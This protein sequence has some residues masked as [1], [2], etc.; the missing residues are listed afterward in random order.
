MNNGCILQNRTAKREV[1]FNLHI[2][3]SLPYCTATSLYSKVYHQYLAKNLTAQQLC[4]AVRFFAKKNLMK[5]KLL[6]VCAP[7]TTT[8]LPFDHFIIGNRKL[9]LTGTIKGNFLELTVLLQIQ[10]KSTCK[11]PL[12]LFAVL[13]RND[14]TICQLGRF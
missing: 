9:T 8:F 5:N 2:D 14:T 12:Q 13:I 3:I 6:K 1:K 4:Y 11:L 10:C 7:G